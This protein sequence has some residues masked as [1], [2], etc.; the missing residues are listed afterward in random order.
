MQLE[1]T[2]IF[3]KH[4]S[5]ASSILDSRKTTVYYCFF[6]QLC[7]DKIVKEHFPPLAM[8]KN[9]LQP[10]SSC[11]SMQTV[12]GV[13]CQRCSMACA[14]GF[15]LWDLLLED[16]GEMGGQMLMLHICIVFCFQA[17]ILVSPWAQHPFQPAFWNAAAVLSMEKI[18]LGGWQ[19]LS[20]NA[21]QILDRE[22]RSPPPFSVSDSGVWCH[23]WGW[24][25]LKGAGA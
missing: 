3:S 17:L 23:G 22:R 21:W 13:A 1:N 5:S 19:T 16:M 20:S 8:R 2:N 25:S 11:H 15:S 10:Q 7:E 18:C 9:Y 12:P 6:N 24:V 14:H 4:F